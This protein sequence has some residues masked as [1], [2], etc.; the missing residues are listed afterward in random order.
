MTV[1]GELEKLLR[2]F[3][4]YY[5]LNEYEDPPFYA[6][7]AFHSHDTHYFLT[8]RAPL[9]EAE[10]NEYVFIAAEG[11]LD[12]KGAKKLVTEAWERGLKNVK[13]HEN[14]RSS[15]VLLIILAEKI[16]DEAKKYLEKCRLYKSYAFSFKGWSAF[17]VVALE[18][19]T[20]TLVSNRRGRDL[21][22]LFN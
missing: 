1:S 5:D 6:S 2:S 8:K 17:K 16:T 14:H 12:E 20:K 9:G 15:D 19:S 4:H 10:S 21:K 22:K 11:V 18:T 7:A 3:R 13:P